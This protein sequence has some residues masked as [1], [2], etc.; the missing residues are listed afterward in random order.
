MQPGLPH[1]PPAS[2][3]LSNLHPLLP[4]PAPPPPIHPSTL[5]SAWLCRRAVGMAFPAFT[6]SLIAIKSILLF[7]RSG[8]KDTEVRRVKWCVYLL[9]QGGARG[10]SVKGT[11][12]YSGIGIVQD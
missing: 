9:Y 7:N 5:P 11:E 8:I 6:S 12:A 4:S 2:F 1:S 10:S 3:L